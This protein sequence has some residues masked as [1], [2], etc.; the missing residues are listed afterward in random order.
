MSKKQYFKTTYTVVVLTEDIPLEY[1]NLGDIYQAISEGDASGEIT[2]EKSVKLTGPECAKALKAQ[3]SDPEFFGLD[4]HG[5]LLD[6]YEQCYDDTLE[7]NIDDDLQ[8]LT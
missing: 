8:L 6:C 4:E 5:E 7:S 3:G 2:D 1:N